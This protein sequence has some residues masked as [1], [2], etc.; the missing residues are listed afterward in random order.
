[1]G[2][3]KALTNACIHKAREKGQSQIVL[4]TTAAMTIAW[5]LYEGMGFEQSK[6]L[7]FTHKGLPDFGFRI[8]DFACRYDARILY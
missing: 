6:D 8:S 5:Q 7:D 1:M 4:H 3:G 2:V